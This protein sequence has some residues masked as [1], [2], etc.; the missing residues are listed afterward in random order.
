MNDLEVRLKKIKTRIKEASKG[1]DEPLLLAVSKVQPITKIEKLRDLGLTHFGESYLQ[2]ALAKVEHFKNSDIVWHFIGPIQ[3]NKTRQIA[4]HFDWVHSVCSVKV[5]RRLS[6]QRPESMPPLN[7]C[8]QINI[9]NETTKSG[10]FPDQAAELYQEVVSLPN[11]ALRGLMCLPKK[12]ENSEDASASFQRMVALKD[13]LDA[14]MDTLSMGM[15]AD[16]EY[17]IKEGS[18]IVRIGT[19]LFGEREPVVRQEKPVAEEAL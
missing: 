17:A 16:L 15:S 13:S 6:S 3:S 14:N 2:E 10:I 11:L 19:A 12:Q 5:A 7:I 4:E 1:I 8:L 18:T 9:D